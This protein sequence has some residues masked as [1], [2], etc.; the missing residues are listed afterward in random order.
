[1][2]T[3]RA[4][5]M[6][7]L[8][9]GIARADD[10]VLIPG[11]ALRAGI[12]VDDFEMLD[13]PVTN[14]EYKLFVDD[15]KYPAP[16]HWQ[17]GRAPSGME[18]WP[19]VFVN[20]YHDAAAY[21]K[22]RTAKE[23]RVCR[24]PTWS[25]FEY[26]ARAGKADASYPWGNEAPA[27][28]ANYD[29]TAAR[30]LGQWR[31]H[32][33]PVKSYP[34]NPWGLYDLA[35]NVWQMVSLYPDVSLGGFVFR[36]TSP[37]D[38]EGWVTGGSWARSE[39]YLRT[40]VAAYQLEGIRLPDLGF[41]VVR[42]PPESTHFRLERRRIVAASTGARR[43]FLSWQLLPND[44]PTA[45][46]HVYRS[47]YRDAAGER[48]T[49]R[50]IQY[51]T[52]F[53]D[54]APPPPLAGPRLTGGPDQPG[55]ERRVYY[56]VRAVGA[57][58][59][60]G[61]PSE[62]AGVEPRDA[63]SG[64]IA[65][66]QPNVK[67]GGFVP[68]FGDLD[69]DGVLDAAFKLDNGITERS[70]DPGVP[71]EI[72]AFTSYGKSIWRRP[73]VRHEEC[74]GNANNVPAL[75]YD[76][77]GDGKAEVVARLQE[78]ETAYLAVLHGETGKVLRKTPWTPL[79]SDLSRSS[80]R[81]HLTIAYLDGRNPAI[82]TQ[83]GLYESEIFTAYDAKLQQL[84]Q[85][86]SFAE[87]NGSGAH[88][89]AVADVDGDGR[90]EVFDGTTLLNA[91]GTVRWSIYRGHPDVVSVK[92]IIPGLAG[93]QVYYAVE[94][95]AHAG[96]Y[97]VDASNGKIIWKVNREDDPRWEHAH[98]GWVADIWEG[99]PG[100]EMMT[101][102]D[103]HTNRDTVLYSADGK[104][105]LNPFPLGWRPVNWLG[106][107]VR[108]LLSGDGRRLGRFNGKDI[109]PLETPG[110][111]ELPPAEGGGFRG[112]GCA[113]AADLAGD[114]RDEM[115]CTGPGRSGGRAVYIYTNTAPIQ[116]REITRLASR[117]YRL[118]LARNVGAGYSSYFEWQAEK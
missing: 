27:G 102:R 51:S 59:K 33:K 63:R 113:I 67:Q 91:D 106:G 17:N 5:L 2:D 37:E 68:M 14:A 43:V 56:R 111:N 4:A 16:Q 20:R 87:T 114:F 50:P 38:R 18:N 10:F 109:E 62:W 74:F 6:V 54:P 35:G 29:A 36:I 61:P 78:G 88:Y 69:G 82:V 81:I 15:A 94:N 95:N 71:V 45:G 70:A 97:V 26:A 58:G 21:V 79:V 83:S 107:A 103:G 93:R 40:G 116:K 49:Q 22:W 8:A 101:N 46:F 99:S 110:P 108:E 96:I 11:G 90:D 115:V 7:L 72:E 57:D 23:G 66:F 80:T 104:L 52:N 3:M 55:G 100:M 25:E 112:G 9:F 65:V 1:M 117:E 73:L 41:R 12:R 39:Y 60:E 24:L 47:Q 19:V 98:T 92:R 118:W 77:D 53:L 34:P 30:T 89:I 86:K 28:R 42:E 48:I 75:L 105:L 31:Q 64:Q 32:L 76:L 44:A 85:F 13:H 84:W